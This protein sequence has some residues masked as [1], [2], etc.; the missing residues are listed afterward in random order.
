[1]FIRQPHL[2]IEL[3]RYPYLTDNIKFNRE[4]SAFMSASDYLN[5]LFVSGVNTG[6]SP[7]FTWE[8]PESPVQDEWEL[9]SSW[10]NL[11]PVDIERAAVLTVG[12]L[13]GLEV[14]NEIFR[15]ELPGR[16]SDGFLVRIISENAFSDLRFRDFTLLCRGRFRQ[17]ALVLT[18]ATRL[19]GKLPLKS[20]LTV[21]GTNIANP[22]TFAG[23]TAEN[24]ADLDIVSDD[25]VAKSVV[26]IK[27]KARILIK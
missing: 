13:A 6:F 19:I 9:F 18:A 21:S 23:L 25:G 7:E 22:V 10:M 16:N 27:L 20:F 24:A 15:G 11:D 3:T 2:I 4:R 14:D 12:C 17:R 8:K 1:M 26:S 5:N